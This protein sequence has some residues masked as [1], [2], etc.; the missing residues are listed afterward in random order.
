M[1]FAM[2]FQGAGV[3]KPALL[4]FNL[5][6]DAVLIHF[7]EITLKGRNRPLF[8][9]RLLDN[10]RIAAKAKDLEIKKTTNVGGGFILQLDKNPTTPDFVECL[11]KIFG[12]A[13]FMPVFRTPADLNAFKNRVLKEIKNH[14]FQSFR[15]TASR[16]D[17]TLSFTSS[18][19]NKEL[20]EAVKNQT[21]AKVDL[22]NPEFTIFAEAIKG[23]IFF[24][25][26]KTKGAGGLP[27]GVSGN[28]VSLLSGGIDSPVASFML[29]RRGC[30]VTFVHFH[31]HP[32]ASRASAEKA[33]ELAKILNEYQFGSRLYL[34]P[35]GEI[36]KQVVLKVPSSLRVIIYRRLM[37]KIAEE[38]AKKENAKALITGESLGQVASQ[39][40]EN[41]SVVGKASS[42]PVFRPLV[43]MD[44]EEIIDRAK[45]IGTYEISI[46]PDEDCCQLFMPKNPETKAREEAVLAAESELGIEKIVDDGL[47]KMEIVLISGDI[48]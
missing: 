32:Y 11:S 35:F 39:T 34:V 36:Q 8:E 7:H 42:L 24:S 46:L 2:F 22:K 48:C 4:H 14:K 1:F 26:E 25:F 28:V 29:M 30:R 19:I 17:K 18:D 15:V 40:L 10:I 27:V 9:K 47:K 37:L 44:K 43:G 16:A 21:K 33:E 23:E 13:N 38:I 3:V 41:I 12:I 45:K 31:S 5:F 6:M 20:G